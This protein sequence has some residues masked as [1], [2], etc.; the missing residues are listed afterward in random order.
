MVVFTFVVVRQL[1]LDTFERKWF[2]WSRQEL[3]MFLLLI[4]S[5]IAATFIVRFLCLRLGLPGTEPV[6]RF[7]TGSYVCYYTPFF[8]WLMLRVSLLN[9]V[10]EE[11]FWRGCVQRTLTQ[12]CHPALAVLGQAILFGLVHFRPAL[13]F[14]QV[15]L[16][17]LIFGIWYYRRNTLLPV[18]VMHIAFNSFM[19]IYECRDLYEMRQ[20]KTT[21]NYVADFIRLSMPAPYD[22]NDDAREFY[23]RAGRL[24]TKLPKELQDMRKRYPTQ[25]SRQERDQVEIWVASNKQALNLVEKATQKP[26]YWVKYKRKNERMPPF[27]FGLEDAR[28]FAFTLDT[29]AVIRTAQGEYEESFDDI[30][31]CYKLGRHWAANKGL[32]SRLLGYACRAISLQTMRTVLSREEIDASLLSHMQR[33]F[34]SFAEDDH[35]GFN[36]T[37]DKLIAMDIIQCIF[38]DDGDGG[39][40]IPRG[41]FRKMRFNKGEYEDLVSILSLGT[42]SDTKLWKS[43]DRRDVTMEVDQYYSLAERAC[44]LSPWQYN[45]DVEG[46]KTRMERI[47]KRNP[48]IRV[49]SP[50]IE[51][52]VWIAGKAQV[53]RDATIA[54]FGILRYKAD[55][56][57][58]PEDLLELVSHD[59]LKDVPEDVYRDG[60]LTY[61]RTSEDFTLY[62]FGADFDDDGGMPSKWGEGEKGGDQ[63]FWPVEQRQ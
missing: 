13:G 11:L 23:T 12:I 46:V 30:E 47:R 20:V 14:L 4:L 25:W 56:G 54:I 16:F 34:E 38:T 26:Y 27:P 9:P 8:V 57:R 58:Y 6:I 48:L 52:L 36:F 2:R 17:S 1:R 31:T 21:H 55:V 49:F 50:A 10:A 42:E 18:I 22:P 63:V 7:Q 61:R 41:A 51:R 35:S 32:A 28:N 44:S 5:I 60:S 45:E 19:A 29:R 39:G 62:S 15:F 24:V 59:Y 33:L 53:D 37:E 40:Y 43:M 3:F